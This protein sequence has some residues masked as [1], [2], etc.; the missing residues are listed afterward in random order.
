MTHD[1][2][3]KKGRE[4]KL[5]VHSH[6]IDADDKRSENIKYALCNLAVNQTVLIRHFPLLLKTFFFS[7]SWIILLLCEWHI[8]WCLYKRVAAY[9]VGVVFIEKV[10]RH[11]TG[12]RYTFLQT[13]NKISR[14]VP[15]NNSNINPHL[16]HTKTIIW[17]RGLDLG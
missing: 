6:C 5:H 1:E 9:I 13:L 17:I 15:N 10:D 7:C 4:K 2:I 14:I 8:A 16:K 11:K 12:T 3:S